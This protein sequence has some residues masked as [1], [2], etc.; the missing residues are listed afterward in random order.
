MDMRRDSKPSQYGGVK[1]SWRD[2]FEEGFRTG[3][4]NHTS[5]G[6]VFLFIVALCFIMAALIIL[7]GGAM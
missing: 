7:V 6:M 2:D 4:D 5:L 3:E 1:R